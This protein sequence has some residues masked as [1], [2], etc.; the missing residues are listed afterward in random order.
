MFFDGIFCWCHDLCKKNKL[1]HK[2]HAFIKWLLCMKDQ[3]FLVSLSCRIIF[4]CSLDSDVKC[5][6][7]LGF[8]EIVLNEV[9][10]VIAQDEQE[11]EKKRNKH[12]NGVKIVNVDAENVHCLCMRAR[13]TKV[14]DMRRASDFFKLYICI[15][16][17]LR[18]KRS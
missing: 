16:V 1:T 13:R 14:L 8:E 5:E 3:Q 7:I 18:H 6:Y 17:P 12:I 2:F 4:F 9:T 11:K 10:F 15:V